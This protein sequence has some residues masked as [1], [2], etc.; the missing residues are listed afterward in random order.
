METVLLICFFIICGSMLVRSMFS[1][2][3][4]F[5][6]RKPIEGEDVFLL[7]WHLLE[8]VA[9]VVMFVALKEVW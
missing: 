1:W 2:Q 8:M 6:S 4:V 5:D 7:F 3:D 9:F